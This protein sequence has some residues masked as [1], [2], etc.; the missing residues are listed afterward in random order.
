MMGCGS[1][2]RNLQTLVGA[3]MTRNHNNRKTGRFG[4]QGFSLIELMVVVAILGILGAAVGV[5]INNDDARLRSF[6]FN[7]GSRVRQA[8]YEAMKQGR[9]VCFDFD[10]N[11]DG[12][13]NDY[14][15][16]VNNDNDSPVAY[17]RWDSAL[18]DTNGNGVCDAAE[19]DCLIGNV[20]SF[21]RG[22]EIYDATDAT[23]TGGPKDP[24]GGSNNNTI[25]DG[26]NT[27]ANSWFR[28]SPSGDA[29]GGS[30]YLYYARAA[31]GGKRVS[32]GPLAIVVNAVGRIV[33]DEWQ[34]GKTGGAAATKWRK[35]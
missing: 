4:S 2:V 35:D 29:L 22:V 31:G 18:N 30:V 23:I 21:P 6:A 25:A 11:S 8:K 19:G 10:E 15:L 28:F 16:W 24:S 7:L 26:L 33:I 13:I 32:S 1:W 17:D 20:V 27:G 12:V 34:S 14:A 3:M 5:Y 9:V